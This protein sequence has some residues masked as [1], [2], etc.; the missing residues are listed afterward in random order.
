MHDLH[1]WLLSIGKPALSVHLRSR[2][3]TSTLHK[4]LKLIRGK[5]GIFHSTVQIED[6]DQA[7]KC[8]NTLH[9]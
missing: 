4:A 6:N 7:M 8:A 1:V 9:Q 2:Q 3:P 5:Y